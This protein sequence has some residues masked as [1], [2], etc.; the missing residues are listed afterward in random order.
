MKMESLWSNARK[1][2]QIYSDPVLFEKYVLDE[3]R[4]F[5]RDLS[6][7]KLY[8]PQWRVARAIIRT[9]IHHRG[10]E[11][12]VEFSR[13]SGKTTTLAWVVS[14]LA[15]KL[16]SYYEMAFALQPD[17]LV[18]KHLAEYK[19]GIWVGIFGPSGEQ[20]ET[21]YQRARAVMKAAKEQLGIKSN[22]DRSDRFEFENG[23][24]VRMQSAS[25][26][27]KIESKT[28]H[29]LICDEAQDT[30]DWVMKKSIFPMGAHTKASRVLIGTASLDIKDTRYFYDRLQNPNADLDELGNMAKF[31]YDYREIIKYSENYRFYIEQEK[32]RIG[33]DSDEFRAAY[34]LQWLVESSLFTSI[35][36]LRANGQQ[37]LLRVK[38]LIYTE[39]NQF[40]DNIYAGIDYGED[41]A[42]TVLTIGQILTIIQARQQGI[43]V[44]FEMDV[45]SKKVIIRILDWLELSGHGRDMT[46]DRQIP[47]LFATL[48]NYSILRVSDDTRGPGKPPHDMLI[49]MFR[50]NNLAHH[51]HTTVKA[52]PW[53]GLT[54]SNLFTRLHNEWWESRIVYP[55]DGSRE[56]K[57][58]KEQFQKLQKEFKGNLMSC[59]KPKDKWARDDYCSSAALLIDAI[60]L[61]YF[62]PEK[63]GVKQ[64]GQEIRMVGS[65]SRGAEIFSD[66]GIPGINEVFEDRWE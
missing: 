37:D 59:H 12:L 40:Y 31:I 14:F 43:N 3:F 25:P 27:A 16:P 15:I 63:S 23:S 64:R 30:Y 66:D 2:N 51:V 36:Q 34:L 60:G 54:H 42:S 55:D 47:H 28:Y 4:C 8:P 48:S 9:V 17:S 44:A 45:H 18:T 35:E 46:Y 38:S 19:H 41:P 26:T 33:E 56:S 32:D 50:H 53:T 61:N 21:A 5:M 52:H 39:E 62:E 1:I 6:D 20:A 10:R 22:M 11:F 13:Q 29:L 65:K 7:W 49:R 58:F 24:F 57:R